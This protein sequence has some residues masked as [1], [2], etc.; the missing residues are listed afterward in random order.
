[1]KRLY[2]TAIRIEEKIAGY[3]LVAIVILVFI[4]SITRFFDRPI[5][6]SVEIAQLLF[7]W[8]IFLGADIVYRYKGHIGIDLIVE[9]F[10]ED[11]QIIVRIINN[12][13]ISFFL[14]ILIFYGFQL[15]YENIG[16][17]FQSFRISYSVC[18]ISVPIG[19]TSMLVTSAVE[20]YKSFLE[21]KSMTVRR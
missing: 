8:L 12:I 2:R 15:S 14:C 18:T 1:M 9:K 21:L 17:T 20:I 11:K 6:W 4:S 10:P 3:F 7:A 13:I 5:I 16:R 19:A